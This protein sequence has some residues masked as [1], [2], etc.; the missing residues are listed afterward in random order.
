MIPA[1]PKGHSCPFPCPRW[2][3]VNIHGRSIHASR[4]TQNPT[5][6]LRSTELRDMCLW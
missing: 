5:L 6:V 4:G 3:R 1:A 2:L